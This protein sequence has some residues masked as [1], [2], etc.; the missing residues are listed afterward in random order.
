MYE[1]LALYD[2]VTDVGNSKMLTPPFSLY[3]VKG[4]SWQA[5]QRRKREYEISKERRDMWLGKIASIAALSNVK[6]PK[7]YCSKRKIRV[8]TFSLRSKDWS[9]VFYT[10]CY[11]GKEKAYEQTERKEEL[12]QRYIEWFAEKRKE[13]RKGMESGIKQGIESIVKKDETC[14]NVYKNVRGNQGGVANL[15]KV[16]TKTMERQGADIRSIAKVQY[17]ICQQAGIMIPEEFIEDVAVVLY[18][19]AAQGKEDENK[20]DDQADALCS[21]MGVPCSV[22]Q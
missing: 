14:V 1:R 20:K 11:G 22:I 21:Q 15:L 3:A 16:L 6:L 10:D 18:A 4:D 9:E 8:A 7:G 19:E 12:I 13:M 17:S 2:I 5:Y